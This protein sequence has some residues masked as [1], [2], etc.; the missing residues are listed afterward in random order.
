MKTLKW[1]CI[2]TF[3][4]LHQLFFGQQSLQKITNKYTPYVKELN[5]GIGVL[6]QKNGQIE[7]ASIGAYNFNANTVFNIGSA[8][9][10]ITAILI[11]QEV[12][13]GTIKLSD[14]I[15]K[16]LKPIKNVPNN[17][18]IESLLRHRSGLG[19]LVGKNF[20]SDFFAKSDSIYNGN[21]LDRIPKENIDKRG[22]FQYCNTNYIL[23]GKILEHIT[24]KSYFDLLRERIFF[25]CK[26]SSSYPYVSKS[27]KNL[28]PPT[29]NQKEVT[30]YLDYRFFANYAYAAGSIASTLNDMAKFYHHLFEEKTLLNKTSLTALLNFDEAN[31]GLG[32]FKFKNGFIGHG[33]N[34]LGYAYREYYHK[35]DKKL[36]LFFSNTRLIPFN[37]MLKEELINY[38]N[39]INSSVSFDKNATSK[40]KHLIGKYLFNTHG[41]KLNME[42]IEKNNHLYFVAQG[43][44]VMLISK[45]NNKLY[46]GDFGVELEIDTQNKEQ[47]IFK[48]NGLV[49]TI[50]RIKS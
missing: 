43:A 3:F 42:I 10:K 32:I 27:L 25:P 46:N 40:Y 44:Q 19:E 6:V 26:M 2:L 34:N 45:E 31:Y 20:E 9:K 18:T 5:Q 30:A 37:K 24:D 39:G 35:K 49:T 50:K 22:K 38:S 15:G 1:I 41:M 7:T 28:A 23:L 17:L 21:I 14:S 11:L 36:I 8:T 47:L 29:H 16:F 48:Q 4:M 13:K 12:E 33:G